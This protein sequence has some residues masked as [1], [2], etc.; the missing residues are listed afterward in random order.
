MIIEELRKI[1]LKKLEAIEKA[2]FSGYPAAVK[3]THQINE[4]SKDFSK[5]SRTKK[6]IILAGRIKSLREHGGSAFSH[7]E[8]GSGAIQ[9]YFKKDRIGEKGYKFFLENF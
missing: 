2:G 9:A 8:D 6:E 4:A 3:R 1:R 7:I 5:L